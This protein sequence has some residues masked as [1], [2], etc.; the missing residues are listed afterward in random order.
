MKEKNTVWKFLIVVLILFLFV[1]VFCVIRYWGYM[2]YVDESA[3][4]SA[5]NNLLIEGVPR[6]GVI[7]VYL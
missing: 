6:V 4:V 2:P 3:N 5:V 7:I 1:S